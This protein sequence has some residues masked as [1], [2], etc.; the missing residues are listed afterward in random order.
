MDRWMKMYSH[1]CY[2]NSKYVQRRDQLR[3]G[4]LDVV[5]CEKS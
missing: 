1:K 4:G 2:S 3:R 5:S